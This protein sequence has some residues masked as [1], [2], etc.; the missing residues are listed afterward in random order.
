MG[1]ASLLL[2]HGAGS[3]PWVWDGWAEDLPELTIQA[4]DLQ[5]DLDPGTA[6]IRDYAAAV[7]AAAEDM[8][9]PLAICGWSMGGLVVMLAAVESPPDLLIVIEPSPPAEIQG[10][11]SHIEPRA[12]TFDPEDVYGPLPGWLRARPESLLARGERKRGVSVPRLA[13]PTVVV[14]GADF[15][16]ERGRAV[17][18]RYSATPLGF[19]GIGHNELIRDTAVRA[20]LRPILA[21]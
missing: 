1:C 9:R 14:F 20:A 5:A 7:R 13:C 18:E 4:V 12:G 21:S 17:A 10:S 8:P 19:P 16:E 3:G 6:S 11:R 2:V 15:A